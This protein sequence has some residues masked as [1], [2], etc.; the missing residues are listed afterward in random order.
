MFEQRKQVLALL[1]GQTSDQLLHNLQQRQH[2]KN[3]DQFLIKHYLLTHMFV[4]VSHTSPAVV[5]EL[6]EILQEPPPWQY[7]VVLISCLT[8]RAAISSWEGTNS[9]VLVFFRDSPMKLA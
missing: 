8:S 4:D 9:R 6:M 1:H 2:K 5:C 7:T 3:T